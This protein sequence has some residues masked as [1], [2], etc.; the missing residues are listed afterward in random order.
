MLKLVLGLTILLCIGATEID[1]ADQQ[2]LQ[3]TED[4]MQL[5]EVGFLL[6]RIEVSVRN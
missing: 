6:P 2:W 4:V 3:S 5:A 1:E